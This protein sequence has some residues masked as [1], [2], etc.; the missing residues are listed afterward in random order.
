MSN[1][2]NNT[3]NTSKYNQYKP[4]VLL[5]W[6]NNMYYAT[7][8]D[9]TTIYR[10]VSLPEPGKKAIIYSAVASK[11]ALYNTPNLGNI[12]YIKDTQDDL[13]L[14]K[15]ALQVISCG[16][17]DKT[18]TSSNYD[19]DFDSWVKNTLWENIPKNI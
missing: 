12:W 3:W 1:N 15:S 4:S 10:F 19:A 7:V 2:L 11:C 18:I 13:N 16:T 8:S 6:Y 5:G 9:N 14:N 17:Y